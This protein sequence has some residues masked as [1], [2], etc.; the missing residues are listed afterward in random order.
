METIKVRSAIAALG[1]AL[2]LFQGVGTVFK[3][4]AAAITTDGEWRCV[5]G[6]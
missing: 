2:E 6:M 4:G 1:H 5:T 3:K